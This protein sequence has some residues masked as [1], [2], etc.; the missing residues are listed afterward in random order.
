MNTQ[1]AV[2]NQVYGIYLWL[3]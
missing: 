1:D 2:G 3:G